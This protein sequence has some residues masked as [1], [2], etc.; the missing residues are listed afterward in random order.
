[1][2][3]AGAPEQAVGRPRT[4]DLVLEGGGVKGVALV[5][6]AT[7]LDEAGWRF[8]RVAGSSAG[9]VVGAVV[10]AMQHAG[11]PMSRVDEIMRTID[12][13]RLRDR[14]PVAR[15]LGWLP[16][17]ADA[18]GALLHLGAYRGRYLEQWVEGV[19]ADL[20]VRT[21]GDLAL[22]DPDGSL[23]PDR[24]FRLVV[25]A[26]DLSR[27]RLLYLPWDLPDQGLDPASFPG[28]RAGRASS[29]IPFAFEPVRLR[30]R[31]GV[32]TLVD[33][34][35]LSTYPIDAFDRTD[36][37][38]P[39]WPTVGVRL[40]SPADE[41]AP[42]VPVGGPV[43]LL[44]NLVHTTIDSTQVR[45]VS[46]PFDVERSIFARPRGVATMDFDI[47]AAQQDRLFAAGLEAGRRWVARHPDGPPLV[48]AAG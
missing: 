35:V 15:A 28:A 39:R 24:S 47:T 34:S 2:S 21:F 13:R 9:A 29:A 1:M 18:W 44:W 22:D 31:H 12:Y 41:R 26:S 6:A 5:G 8:A 11:E 25:T 32:S 48:R 30:G 10:A 36:G 17:V 4:T 20:G 16:R 40:S 7:A 45:H 37:R 14:R 23:G 19:L 38:P 46:D 3:D 33:G 42:A 27:Q 43:S